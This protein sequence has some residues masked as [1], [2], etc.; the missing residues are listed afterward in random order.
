ME[1][2]FHLKKKKKL[3]TRNSS[4]WDLSS[5]RGKKISK[6]LKFPKLEFHVCFFFFTPRK[7]NFELELEFNKLE[8]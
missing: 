8:F 7:M 1:L 4:L 5:K 3:P 2:E 6:E